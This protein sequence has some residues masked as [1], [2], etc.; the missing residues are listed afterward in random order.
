MTKMTINEAFKE[1]SDMSQLTPIQK[2]RVTETFIETIRLYNEHRTIYRSQLLATLISVMVPMMTEGAFLVFSSYVLTFILSLSFW[3]I[4]KID[5]TSDLEMQIR[6][7]DPIKALIIA[8]RNRPLSYDY[9]VDKLDRINENIE[10]DIK[11]NSNLEVIFSGG[12]G[13][14]SGSITYPFK[15]FKPF[16]RSASIVVGSIYMTS[17]VK[18][19]L[20]KDDELEERLRQRPQE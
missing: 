2:I 13:A 16:I 11:L 3:Q 7:W 10:H 8:N 6:L 4:S 18:E 20:R 19:T 17:T 12:A 5:H 1:F 14:A 15:F 9:I